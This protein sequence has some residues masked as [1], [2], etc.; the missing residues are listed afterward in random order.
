M[1]IINRLNF[2]HGLDC[3]GD[4]F[5]LVEDGPLADLGLVAW[6]E[7]DLDTI[8]PVDLPAAARAP[9]CAVLYLAP[10]AASADWPA[11]LPGPWT[12]GEYRLLATAVLNTFDRECYCYD[13]EDGDGDP[14]QHCHRCEGG[15]YVEHIGGPVA[16][17]GYVEFD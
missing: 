4:T 5:E 14:D 11:T 9:S 16:L 3:S 15:G 12:D 1:H 6:D 7:P 17:Y 2:G 10:F 13:R 8:W